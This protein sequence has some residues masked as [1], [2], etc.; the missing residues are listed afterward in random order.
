M[1]ISA[2]FTPRAA[3]SARGIYLEGPGLQR[4]RSC[5]RTGDSIKFR[6]ERLPGVCSCLQTTGPS[7]AAV[8]PTLVRG[9]NLR[10]A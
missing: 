2:A 9:V 8:P 1:P 4:T 7:S 3:T 10:A 5:S 6:L